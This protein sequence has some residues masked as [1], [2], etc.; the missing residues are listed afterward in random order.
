MNRKGIAAVLLLVWFILNGID[1][2]Q[3]TGLIQYSSTEMDK[4]VEDV[5]DNFEEA[6]KP[7]ENGQTTS[8]RHFLHLY[9]FYFDVDENLSTPGTPIQ[10]FETGRKFSIKYYKTYKLHQVFLI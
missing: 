6:V 1:F 7:S 5:L 4:S 10:G 8:N 9:V 2:L 3:D